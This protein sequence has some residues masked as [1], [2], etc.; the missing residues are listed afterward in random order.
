MSTQTVPSL[1]GLALAGGRSTR[2]GTDKGRLD[3]GGVAAVVRAF[4]LLSRLLGQVFVSVRVDQLNESPYAQLPAI[5]DRYLDVGPAS[6]LLSAW[7]EHPETAWLVLAVDMPLVDEAMLQ[8]LVEARRPDRYATGFLQLD[9]RPEPL[10]TIYEPRGRSPLRRRSASGNSSLRG[11]LMSV[12]TELGVPAKRKFLR[13]VDDPQA[14]R[15]ARETMKG[16]PGP[17]N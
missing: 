7:D 1:A 9:G 6:G 13:S 2:M 14:H 5:A 8:A 17:E 16:R 12:P 4:E 11:F 10:C 3:Y 15:L